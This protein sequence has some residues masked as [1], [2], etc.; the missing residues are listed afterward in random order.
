[1][2]EATDTAIEHKPR[3][4]SVASRVIAAVVGGLVLA[5]A[6]S[7]FLAVAVPDSRGLGLAL[8]L[9][10]VVPI[11]TAAMCCGFLARRPWRPW[12]VYLSLAGA[13]AAAAWLLTKGVWR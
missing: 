8:G 4:V 7:V 2:I 3:P 1:M 6:A 9:V 10:L 5:I 12:A 11:W 13:F